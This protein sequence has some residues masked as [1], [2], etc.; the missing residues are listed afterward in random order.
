MLP[1]ICLLLSLGLGFFCVALFSSFG[2]K[3]VTNSSRF[4]FYQYSPCSQK[5]KKNLFPCGS[6]LCLDD[7]PQGF[8]HLLI[9]I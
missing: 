9:S 5:K 6:K 1:E 2:I 7:D 8:Y 3:I 4:V